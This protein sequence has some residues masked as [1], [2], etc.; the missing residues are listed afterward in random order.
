MN[1]YPLEKYT[2]AV[3]ILSGDGPFHQRLRDAAWE[4]GMAGIGTWGS[5][6]DELHERHEQ[7]MQRCG[8]RGGREA[9]LT[10]DEIEIAEVTDEFVHLLVR[11]A[12]HAASLR[13]APAR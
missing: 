1:Y 8:A 12:E 11:I 10:L 13:L 2:M 3:R 6:A 7:L 4:A 9:T 5:G